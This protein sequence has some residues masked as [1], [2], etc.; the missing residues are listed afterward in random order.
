MP[1]TDI[2]MSKALKLAIP[3]PS[4]LVRVGA[5]VR[6]LVGMEVGTLITLIT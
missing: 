5:G 4:L 6:V 2:K 1:N 3:S